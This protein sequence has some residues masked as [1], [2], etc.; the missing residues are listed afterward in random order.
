MP[1]FTKKSTVLIDTAP[2][3]DLIGSKSVDET[4]NLT[5]KVSAKDADG[6][7]LAFSA[8]GLPEGANF[9]PSSGIFTW[10]P[11]KGQGG[12]YTVAF[13]VSD[14]YLNDS[15]DVKIT[16]RQ[17]NNA[18]YIT[19]FEPAN[20]S[21][22]NEGDNIKIALNASDANGQALSYTIRIDGNV[23]TTSPSY[24]WNTNYSSSGS[25]TLELT[26]SNGIEEVKKVNTIYINNSY[27]RWDVNKDGVVDIRD[28]TIVSKKYGTITKAPYPSWD[29]NQD[30]RVD[31]EDLNLVK[32]H[33][34]EKIE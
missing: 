25:H 19:S 24:I 20:G 29:V 11:S 21:V 8:S 28:V 3:L 7:N 27:P 6:D 34:G 18:P 32:S 4:E 23:Y 13:K 12:I 9:D 1:N 17:P 14:G 15:E 30:G 22:F 33:F 10:I 2:E 5:F 26:V 31:T 16:V